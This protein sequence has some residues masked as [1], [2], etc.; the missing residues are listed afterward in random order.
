MLSKAALHGEAPAPAT[1][2]VTS[3]INTI[4]CWPVILSPGYW[5]SAGQVPSR[6]QGL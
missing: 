6:Q 4:D 1:F 2:R 3:R 5:A